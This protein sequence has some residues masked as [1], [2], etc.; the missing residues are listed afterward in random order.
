VVTRTELVGTK[1]TVGSGLDAGCLVTMKCSATA[2]AA[3]ATP[4]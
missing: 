3:T 1:R 2:A 4:M